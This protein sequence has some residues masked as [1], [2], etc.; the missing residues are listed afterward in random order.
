MSSLEHEDGRPAG[1]CP[2]PSTAAP[3]GQNG[4]DSAAEEK[5][6]DSKKCRPRS[7]TKKNAGVLNLPNGCSLSPEVMIPVEKLVITER[8]DRG[9]K[10]ELS[11]R[12]L[13]MSLK[14]V[15]QIHPVIVRSD[16]ATGKYTIVAG[17]RR[18]AAAILVGIPA[19]RCRVFDGPDAGLPYVIS[20]VENAHRLQESPWGLAQKLKAAIKDGYSQKE[21]AEMFER[22]EAAVS[23]LLYAA[24]KLPAAYCKR[25]ENGENL[26]KVVEEHKSAVRRRKEMEDQPGTA[27]TANGTP[28]QEGPEAPAAPVTPGPG[29]E[30]E[31]SMAN[32]APKPA[33]LAVVNHE[34]GR[35]NHG[36]I[37]VSITTTSKDPPPDSEMVAALRHALGRIEAKHGTAKQ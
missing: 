8:R 18:T 26:Y 34:H 9:P 36:D 3:G 32:D 30:Q 33:R 24:R 19:L 29:K 7:D 15:G 2:H 12:G 5:A 21:L 31:L 37:T 10:A 23:A 11:L 22:S 28:A 17:N 4:P 16:P 25:I 14:I 27:P 1:Q 35:F 13:G 20:A 6:D